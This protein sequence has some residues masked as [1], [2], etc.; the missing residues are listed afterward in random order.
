MPLI[1]HARGMRGHQNKVSRSI[2][3]VKQKE[4]TPAV[5]GWGFLFRTPFLFFRSRQ[6]GCR[7][8]EPKGILLPHWDH[9]R[10]LRFR[11]L[12]FDP[13]QLHHFLLL[14]SVRIFLGLSGH[15]SHCY[16]SSCCELFDFPTKKTSSVWCCTGTQ[17]L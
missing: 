14:R 8:S 16:P 9:G 3:P 10:P 2:L 15:W 6:S 7:T 4:K 5:A 12:L 13:E 1:R 11:S 17:V